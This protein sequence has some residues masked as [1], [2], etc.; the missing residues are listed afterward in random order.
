MHCTSENLYF[1]T[2]YVPQQKMYES[3]INDMVV[4]SFYNYFA[5]DFKV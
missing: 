4:M 3:G 2:R 1:G 5:D